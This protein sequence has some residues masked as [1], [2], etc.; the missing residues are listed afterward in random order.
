[1]IMRLFNVSGL[2]HSALPIAKL[3]AALL[4]ICCSVL[5]CSGGGGGT[6]PMSNAPI[7]AP[8][9]DPDPDP[10]PDPGPDPDP[11]PDPE[12]ALLL[13]LNFD[14]AE[15]VSFAMESVTNEQFDINTNF[16]SPERVPGIRGTALR[17]DGF[18]TWVNGSLA[19]SGVSS[20]TAQAWVALP[21]YP[22]DVELPF[23]Q[24]SPSSIINVGTADSGFSFDLDT[25]GNWGFSVGLSGQQYT[26][27]AAGPM[28]LHE[29]VHVAATLDGMAGRL[30][31][32][33][34]S[35]T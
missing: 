22:S 17:T 3:A 30:T 29:W 33:M 7:P 2:N 24:L 20:L 21:N 4:I 6:A 25:F 31:L 5:A 19:V 11:D 15:G 8:M 28:P 34:V 18:S 32:Y 16:D 10:E 13:Q 26:V 14:E 23:D 12:P 35:P 27:Q 1:M 9:P